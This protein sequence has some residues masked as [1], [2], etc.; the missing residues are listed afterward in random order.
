MTRL[1]TSTWYI[2]SYNA[3]GDC[4]NLTVT[5]NVLTH[6]PWAYNTAECYGC[7]D[8]SYEPTNGAEFTKLLI[9]YQGKQLVPNWTT[10]SSPNPICS[11]KAVVNSPNSVTITFQQ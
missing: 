2:G 10:A 9:T 11:E 4:T 1:S 5:R 6:Q 3:Q 8:C 7:E